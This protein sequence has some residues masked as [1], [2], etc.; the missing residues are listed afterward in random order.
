MHKYILLSL[1]ICTY[2]Y[3]FIL[4]LFLLPFSF[5]LAFFAFFFATF[6]RACLFRSALHVRFGIADGQLV[7]RTRE[8]WIAYCMRMGRIMRAHTQARMC[9]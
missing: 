4:F 7:S 8:L 5:A 3:I 2:I 1:C 9:M 6:C